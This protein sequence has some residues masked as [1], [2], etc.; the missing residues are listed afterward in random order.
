MVA[1]AILK[2]PDWGETTEIPAPKLVNGEW[3]ERPDNP[4]TIILWENFDA[5][6][7]LEDFYETIEEPVL[8]GKSNN[9]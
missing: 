9:R 4:R 8:V 3:V 7:I 5:E 2:N 1:V 6:A